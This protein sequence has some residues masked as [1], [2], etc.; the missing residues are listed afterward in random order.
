[1]KI[2]LTWLR[3]K[4]E[5]RNIL[6]TLNVTGRGTYEPIYSLSQIEIRKV[7]RGMLSLLQFFSVDQN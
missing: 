7:R 4:I 1:M 5:L 6:V 3:M 2:S